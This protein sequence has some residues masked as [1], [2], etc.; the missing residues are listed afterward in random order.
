MTPR[1]IISAIVAW[2][3]SR[4]TQ[5]RIDRLR[6]RRIEL[7][8]RIMDEA[9][10]HRRVSHLQAQLRN[11]TNELLRLEQRRVMS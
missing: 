10:H 11:A 9:R 7:K 3:Q 1:R 2:W 6:A 8:E 4:P 5:R